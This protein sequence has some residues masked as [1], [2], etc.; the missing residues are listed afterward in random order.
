MSTKPHTY[1]C[2]QCG[3]NSD[4]PHGDRAKKHT[5]KCCNCGTPFDCY[6]SKCEVEKAV[7]INGIGPYCQMCLCLTMALHYAVIRPWVDVE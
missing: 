4:C 1:T 7:K 3:T 5:H 6:L 2:I